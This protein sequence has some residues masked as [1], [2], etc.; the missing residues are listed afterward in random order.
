MDVASITT[1]L[2][3][4]IAAHRSN[5]DSLSARETALLELGALTMASEHYRL[6]GYDVTIQN[7]KNGLFAAKLTSRGHP[8]NFSW[9]R[10][11]SKG[12]DVVE[13]HCNL[14]VEGARGDGAI[15]VVDVA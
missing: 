13:I 6:I 11:E 7:P 4:F 12:G 3:E 2:S 1:A 8:F 5:F 9:F 14:A 10:C 15:Y